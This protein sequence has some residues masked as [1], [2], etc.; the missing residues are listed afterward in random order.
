VAAGGDSTCAIV[1]GTAVCWGDNGGGQLGIGSADEAP[2]PAPGAAAHGGLGVDAIALGA[3]HACA[4]KTS[5]MVACWGADD[6]G[7]VSGAPG[8]SPRLGPVEVVAARQASARPVAAGARHTCAIAADGRVVCWGDNQRGQLGADLNAVPQSGPVMVTRGGMLLEG[9]LVVEA[10]DDWTLAQTGGSV[11]S[12][13]ANDTGQLGN[14]AVLDRDY[15][16]PVLGV[17]SDPGIAAGS[18][19]GCVT[20]PDGIRCWGDNGK[21]QLGREATSGHNPAGLVEAPFSPPATPVAGGAHTCALAGGTV[22][23]WG[24]NGAGQ[25]GVSGAGES[26][27]PQAVP[28]GAVATLAAGRQ[29]TCALTGDGR[30]YCW[31]ANDRGQLGDGTTTGGPTPRR[32]KLVCPATP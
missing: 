23:C 25:L 29:H 30:L 17:S 7:Q 21:G 32:V 1:G 19:H 4:R 3:R 18:G 5:G 26:Q 11:Y 12:W 9:V 6:R 27:T 15:A 16:E 2:H 31:G 14:D 13:G 24:D 10:G 28:V 20:Q 22:Y 8:D